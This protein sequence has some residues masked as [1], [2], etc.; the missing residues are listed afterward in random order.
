MLLYRSVYSVL[1]SYFAGIQ[2][3]RAFLS[4][5]IQDEIYGYNSVKSQAQIE[6]PSVWSDFDEIAKRNLDQVK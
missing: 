1:A 6:C 2:L 4:Q 5:Y 3:A